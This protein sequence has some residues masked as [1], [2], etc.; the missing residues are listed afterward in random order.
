MKK[1]WILLLLAAA[2]LIPCSEALASPIDGMWSIASGTISAVVSGT[3]VKGY[4][5]GS[6]PSEFSIR[7]EALPGGV[8][9]FSIN[10]GGYVNLG[11]TLTSPEI[12]SGFS[13]TVSLNTVDGLTKISEGQYYGSG[14]NPEGEMVES[15][16]VLLDSST[17]RLTESRYSQDAEITFR[18]VGGGNPYEPYEPYDPYDPYESGRHGGGG[19]NATGGL[20]MMLPLLPLFVFKR[21]R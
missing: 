19:C 11:Y 16:L 6:V 2:L 7:M 17:L 3:Q 20:L 4:I 9:R 1:G 21:N 12:L 18:R 15:S 10:N 14:R 5:Y 13:D 8:Y